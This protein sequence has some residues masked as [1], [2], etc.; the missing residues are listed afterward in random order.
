[1]S[2]LL[3]T[4]VCIKLIKGNQPSFINK[5]K[6]IGMDN[7]Y[8][9]SIVRYELY[10]GAFKSQKKEEN[11]NKLEIFL[12]SFKNLDFDIKSAEICGR[13]RSNLEFKGT[14]IGSYDIMIASIALRNKLT[15]VTHNISEFSRIKDLVIE[16]WEM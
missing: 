9:C 8:I 2:F 12:N 1:M 15:L 10:Y 13:I 6:T 16:D 4:N 5:I 7:I 14:P 3:D 11:L